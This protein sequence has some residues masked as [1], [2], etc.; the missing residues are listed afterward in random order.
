MACLLST[1]VESEW[2]S[3]AKL[4]MKRELEKMSTTT[5]NQLDQSA[6]DNL[7]SIEEEIET[8]S[9][10]FKPKPSKT[11]VIKLDPQKDKIVPAENDRF[12]DANGNP[13]KRY[14]CKITHV[15]NGKQ[16]LCY[17]SKTVCQQI[18]EQLRKGFTVLKVVRTG[19]YRST[20][21]QIEG[22]VTVV[23]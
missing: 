2:S 9:Q 14:E 20:T 11:Y 3:D 13:I 6:I 22:V 1:W 7:E 19:A 12:K 23:G 4:P 10:Y 21:Y 15:N 16:Q 5:T 17:T 18:I 8:S